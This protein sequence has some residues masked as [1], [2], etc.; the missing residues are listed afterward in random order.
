MRGAKD[1][2]AGIE[3]LRDAQEIY[4]NAT[5]VAAGANVLPARNLIVAIDHDDIDDNVTVTMPSVA[6]AKGCRVILRMDTRKAAKSITV[7][8]ASDS[9]GWSNRTLD[10]ANES[11]CYESDGKKWHIWSSVS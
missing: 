9:V 2:A 11:I 4:L 8:H 1:G 3:T 6:A 7:A 10:A 5:T